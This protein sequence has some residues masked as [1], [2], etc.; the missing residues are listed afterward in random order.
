MLVKLIFKQWISKPGSIFA[1]SAKA[2]ATTAV[3]AH[4][5]LPWCRPVATRWLV[6]GWES[7]PQSCGIFQGLRYRVGRVWGRC[8]K[9][10]RIGPVRCPAISSRLLTVHR[11]VVR[12]AEH[13]RAIKIAKESNNYTLIKL[14]WI[15]KKFYK[16]KQQRN[17]IISLYY[18]VIIKIT[19][20]VIQSLNTKLLLTEVIMINICNAVAGF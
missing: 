10:G 4:V 5:L 6:V 16:M 2:V 7:W 14:L 20:L 3:V 17:G 1:S 19:W 15:T 13:N 8:G 12:R 9:T 11:G 18:N